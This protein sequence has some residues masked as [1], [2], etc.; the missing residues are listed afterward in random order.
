MCGVV[1]YWPQLGVWRLQVYRPGAS[2]WRVFVRET[3]RRRWWFIVSRRNVVRDYRVVSCKNKHNIEKPK[4]IVNQMQQCFHPLQNMEWLEW[5]QNGSDEVKEITNWWVL[6][7]E[8]GLT[9]V[10]FI[11][12]NII[13][14][15]LHCYRH[16]CQKSS[17][18]HNFYQWQTRYSQF[19]LKNQFPVNWI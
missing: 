10:K 6:I 18:S 15:S 7:S 8:D 11:D 4:T 1:F 13:K 12:I 3:D 14:F 19:Y 17:T 2:C 5:S 16:K 9:L